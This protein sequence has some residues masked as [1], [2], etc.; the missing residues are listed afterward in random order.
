MKWVCTRESTRTQDQLGL[1]RHD[2]VDHARELLGALAP[3]AVQEDHD[4][5]RRAERVHARYSWDAVTDAYEKLL[6]RLAH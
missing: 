6:T 3:I 2:G 1:P 4:L 5:G